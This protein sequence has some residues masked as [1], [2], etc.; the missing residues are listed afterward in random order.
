MSSFSM[1][2]VL[3]MQMKKRAQPPDAYTYSLLLRGLGS[4]SHHPNVV[5]KALSVY[6]SLSNPKSD[7]DLMTVHTNL[8]LKLCA[9]VGDVDNMWGIAGRLD[10]KGVNTADKRTYDIIFS[11]ELRNA[12]E[13]AP[14]DASH[15][16]LARHYEKSILL[17][18]RIWVDVIRKWKA[19]QI[20]MDESLVGVVGR[21]LLLSYRPRDWDDVLSLVS[22]TQKIPRMTPVLGTA[23]HERAER[24]S[25]MG[26]LMLNSTPD[27]MKMDVNDR[28]LSTRGDEFADT[29][30][31]KFVPPGRNTLSLLLHASLK[32]HSKKAADDYWY[33][34]IETYKVKP[35]Y[36]NYKSYLRV[37]RLYHNSAQT[38][39]L[40]RKMERPGPDVFTIAMSACTR[41]KL[42]RNSFDHATEL[43]KLMGMHLK[44]FQL[45]VVLKYLL[46]ATGTKDS[47]SIEKAVVLVDDLAQKTPETSMRGLVHAATENSLDDKTAKQ[48]WEVCTSMMHCLDRL[49]QSSESNHKSW[50][51][52]RRKYKQWARDIQ[53]AHK[54]KK[55][56]L[57]SESR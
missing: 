56:L 52:L 43:M 25:E 50:E 55:Q 29:K 6:N 41:D 33:L 49:L 20:T 36:E 34:F 26:E 8:I 27:D 23:K 13:S 18:R 40:L 24:W 2:L 30:H 47:G 21:I 37:L 48:V 9:D 42:N 7:V 19:G 3:T 51:S 5:Q 32:L 10:E 28:T 57:A 22:Q 11:A 12:V 45:G 44:K 14:Q 35:D 53:H 17:V 46:L 39:E 4:Q 16:E 38:V 15:E 1:P 54:G 31:A